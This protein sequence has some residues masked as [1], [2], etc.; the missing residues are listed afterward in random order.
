MPVHN[1]APYVR[2]A[3]ES[4]LA[5]TF[6]DFELV[7]IDDGSTDGSGDIIRSYGDPR[8]RLFRHERQRGLSASLN[9]GLSVAESDLIARQDGDDLSVPGRLERQVAVMSAN[10]DLA[11]L[12]GQASAIDERGRALKPVAR[13]VD[14]VSIRWYGLFDNPFIHSAVMFRRRVVRELGG[15]DASFDPTSQDYALWSAI[16]RRHPIMNLPE[17]IVTYRVRSSSIFGVVDDAGGDGSARSRFRDMVRTLVGE[18]IRSM[19]GADTVSAADAELMSAFALGADRQVVDR[20]L[21]VFFRLLRL[22]REREP[23]SRASADFRMTLARQV[24]AVAYRMAPASRQA[25]WRVYSAACRH[26]PAI[27]KDLSWSRALVLT[28]LGKR[29]REGAADLRR[30]SGTVAA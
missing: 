16:M 26:E 8:I 20:F 1:V 24:D 21:T 12:G 29:A 9:L 13:S 18:N 5:Q 7:V 19:F 30:F 17:R 15:Y 6:A 11:L 4:L 14:P 3:V 10:P 2:P 25:A 22:Y 27:V 23:S 28:V